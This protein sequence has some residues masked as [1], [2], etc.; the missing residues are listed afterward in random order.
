MGVAGTYVCFSRKLIL[1]TRAV[2]TH[3]TS[4]DA[5][6]SVNRS[7]NGVIDSEGVHFLRPQKIVGSYCLRPEVDTEVFL[8]KLVPG[9]QPDVLDFVLEKG[10][11]GLV[12]EAFGLGGLH[13][14][15]RNLVEKLRMLRHHGIRVLVVSQCMYEKADLSIYEVG[16]QMLRADVISGRDMTTEAAVTKMMW[17]LKQDQPDEWLARNL[18][19]EVRET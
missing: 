16:T 3:T 8:L 9:T 10:Y 19:G 14:I 7:L 11:R 13:Y 6:D 2:K 1:G 17:A 15:R 12:I 5:F 4:F 18:C